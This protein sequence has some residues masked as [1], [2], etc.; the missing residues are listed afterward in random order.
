MMVGIF[1]GALT[2]TPAFSAAKASAMDEYES[3]VT[4][5]YGIAYIFGVLGVVI[6]VQLV[7]K[8]GDVDMDIERDL[9]LD[10]EYKIA[11][12]V[13]TD[14]SD[15]T[16]VIA[17]VKAPKLF[18]KHIFSTN[19]LNKKPTINGTNVIIIP[20]TKYIALK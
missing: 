14:R 1:A 2:S 7:P 15:K 10:K 12:R 16:E 4:V 17:P 5:G 8:I 11:K 19:L 13:G 6:F 3:A 18:N 20:Y 9:I